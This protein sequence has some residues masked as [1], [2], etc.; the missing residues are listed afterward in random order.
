MTKYSP[1]IAAKAI[2]Q[3][4]I[5]KQ[6]FVLSHAINSR[7]NMKCSFCEYWKTEGEEMELTGIFKLL[8]Q[9]RAFGILVYNAWT[10]EPLLRE[11]LPE[12]LAYAKQLG[13][14]TS[15][16]TNGLLLEKRIGELND[17][18]YLSVS[19]DGTSSYKDIRGISLDRIMPGILKARD[20]IRKPLLLNCVISGK[21]LDDI[22]ELITMAKELD[23]KI[24]FEPM[25]E[26]K[27]IDRDTWEN[28]GIRDTEKY[29]KTV[30]RI[31]EMKKEGYPIINS[32]TYLEMIRDLRT[33]FICHANDIILN[34]TADGTIENCRVH[35]APIGH[36]DDGIANVWKNTREFRK[37]MAYKCKKC[38]FSGYVE[39]SLMY[40]FNLEVA[41]H[42][43]LM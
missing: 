2:W 19:V 31:M 29:R 23:V 6:P 42:Y 9:A 27:G 8:D 14:V 30:G 40:N 43:E 11:D 7:C 18:D 3:M 22:E 35:R 36:I 16:I 24:S 26:F 39:N 32:Y 25:Y 38:L 21:N 15:L 34:V 4:R 41:Q 10:V 17:L 33:D 20:M 5:K 12:I 1:L 13:M 37:D 28:M